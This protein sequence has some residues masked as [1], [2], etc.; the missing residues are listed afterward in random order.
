MAFVRKA[1][2]VP[3]AADCNFIK[4]NNDTNELSDLY[5]SQVA[6]EVP[7]QLLLAA[8]EKVRL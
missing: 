8:V 4:V 1:S 6:P 2:V 3:E 7:V 5:K